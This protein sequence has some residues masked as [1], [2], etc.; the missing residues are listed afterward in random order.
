[1]KKTP[2]EDTQ[3][4]N[5]Q[6]MPETTHY[7]ISHETARITDT[8]D[9][10]VFFVVFRQPHFSRYR[11]RLRFYLRELVEVTTTTKKKKNGLFIE[12]IIKLNWTYRFRVCLFRKRT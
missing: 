10:N 6:M 8:F 11:L 5:I 3:R 12:H 1:M 2:I 4:Y 7:N 9:S